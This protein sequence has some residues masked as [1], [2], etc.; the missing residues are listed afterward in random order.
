MSVPPSGS[1]PLSGF[2]DLHSHTDE[3]DGT[4]TPRQ[5]VALANQIGLDALAITDHDT[6]AGY[7]KA[8]AAA[9]AGPLDLV[10]GIELNSRFYIAH[11]GD[12]RSVHLLA[13]FPAGGPPLAF[14][15]WLWK[16][17]EDRRIRNH[18]L[19]DALRGQGIDITLEEVE[20][21]GR[22]L[23][24]RP[25]FA[26]LLLEK[27]YAASYQDA[28]ERYIG[29][30]APTFVERPSETTEQTIHI[31]RS[32]HGIPVLAH[33][34]RLSLSLEAE[35]EAIVRL[36][37][38]GL[39]GLEVYHSE[40]TPEMQAHY[41]ALADELDLLPTGGSDFHGRLKPDVSLGTGWNGNI[42]VPRTLLDN[43]REHL[44]RV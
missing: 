20:A 29:E 4:L 18:R 31:V 33:P 24:G 11:D 43:M 13:Y 15:Q 26:R 41:Q 30:G 28:F 3:S 7:E 10:C 27:G 35:R 9:H 25:H 36:K 40:H 21:R 14:N 44:A 37:R 6:F 17:Q 19:V 8:R 38:A 34:I 32:A 12:Y 16:A 1:A 22:S 23:T 42:R 2:I 5:L 39:L